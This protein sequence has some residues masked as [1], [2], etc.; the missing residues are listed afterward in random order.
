MG[1]HEVGAWGCGLEGWK[2]GG[3]TQRCAAGKFGSVCEDFVVRSHE[4]HFLLL[5]F[6]PGVCGVQGKTLASPSAFLVTG[7]NSGLSK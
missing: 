1:T 5:D 3:R 7:I 4:T 6:C 2:G